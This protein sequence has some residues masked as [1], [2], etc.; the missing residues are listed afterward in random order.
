MEASFMERVIGLGKKARLRSIEAAENAYSYALRNYEFVENKINELI[1]ENEIF[2]SSARAEHDE[3]KRLYLQEIASHNSSIDDFKFS[4]F[5][6]D[7]EAIEA[8]TLWFWN[9]LITV[10]FFHKPLTCFMWRRA[11]NY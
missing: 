1:K 11:K 5:D 7:K 10:T 8:Y 2:L 6:K 9:V 4:Y 3:S